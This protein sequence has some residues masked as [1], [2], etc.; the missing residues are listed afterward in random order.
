VTL[1]SP[2]SATSLCPRSRPRRSRPPRAPPAAAPRARA[3]PA[4]RPR[5]RGQARQTAEQSVVS[6]S[7]LQNNPLCCRLRPRR[8][9]VHWACGTRATAAA[10]AWHEAGRVR[11]EALR[12]R[13]FARQRGCEPA[14]ASDAPSPSRTWPNALLRRRATT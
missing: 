10:R 1:R 3:R 4:Q 6:V 2:R 9:A 5:A 13:R 14:A 11:G 12:R 7:A 8:R